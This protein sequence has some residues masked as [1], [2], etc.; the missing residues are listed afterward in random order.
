MLVFRKILYT[1][2]MD[3]HWFG[4]WK[5]G[6]PLLNNYQTKTRKLVGNLKV[7]GKL[8]TI[9]N[10]WKCAP[11]ASARPFLILA[12][13]PK[14]PLNAEIFFKNEIFRKRI[15]KNSFCRAIIWWKNKNL[16]KIADTSF[17]KGCFFGQ[18]SNSYKSGV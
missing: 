5:R 8:N 2:S 17:K 14:Q 4:L 13:N 9:T 7:I 11:K 15:I 16:I 6:L 1:Y 12:N 10:I 3:G 18:T